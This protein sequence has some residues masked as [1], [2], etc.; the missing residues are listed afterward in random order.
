MIQQFP[1]FLSL[2]NLFID[3]TELFVPYSFPQSELHRVAS[4]YVVLCL[5]VAW[6]LCRDYRLHRIPVPS[7]FGK[8]P[9]EAVERPSTCWFGTSVVCLCCLIS[10][11]RC[12]FVH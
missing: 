2:Q 10:H 9:S 6:S 7:F 1:S 3:I 11:C 4:C 8:A 5:C 12:S